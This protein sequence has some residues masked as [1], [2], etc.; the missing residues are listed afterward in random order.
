MARVLWDRVPNPTRY[1]SRSLG[2]AE[3]QLRRAIHVIKRR[4]GMP[5]GERVII[6]DD[7]RVT[8]ANGDELGN[9]FDE[10]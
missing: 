5:G 7:G 4:A 3:W 8:D 6:Y 2:V 10:I 1:V 9:I